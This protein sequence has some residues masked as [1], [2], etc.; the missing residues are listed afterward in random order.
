MR[1]AWLLAL[2]LS[3]AVG[4]AATLPAGCLKQTEFRCATNEQCTP[5]G[6]CEAVGYCS[7]P[8]SACGQRF[9]DSAGPYANQCVDNN[10]VGSD[11]GVDGSPMIDAPPAATCPS[12][13]MALP[14]DATNPHRYARAP[15]SLNWTQ[16]QTYCANV[17]TKA[18]LAIPDDATELTG[19]AMVAGAT[20][21]WVGISDITTE[22]TFV[23]V[24]GATAT[25][26]PWTAGQ[27]DGGTT[28]NC[29]A[30]TATNFSDEKCSGGGQTANRPA[31]CE[32]VP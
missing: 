5:N 31:V 28:E 19:L 9:G 1:A 8:D 16:Q 13:F 17:S 27:P 32:C 4:L 23:T 12:N 21:F 2:S 29:V 20:P 7:F 22:N 15:A 14:N 30:A 6:T 3:L 11:G 25:F 24:L 18:Y 26:L 10:P